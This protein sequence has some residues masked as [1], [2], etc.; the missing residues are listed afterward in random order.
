MQ[1]Q[2]FT[3][4]E[5]LVV[6]AIIAILASLLLPVLSKA[7]VRAQRTTC[8]NNLR[9][10]SL[11][12]HLY[13]GDNNDALPSI[14]ITN[15][16]PWSYQWRFFKELTKSYD[17]LSGSSSPQDTLF[18]CPA[19]IFYYS[20]VHSTPLIHGSMH[21]DPWADYSSYWFSRLNLVPNPMT[22]GFYHG[23][24]GL[25]IS[26]IR[27]PVQTLMVADQ[28]ACFAYSWHQPLPLTDPGPDKINDAKSMVGFVDGHVSY[29]NI[30]WD[31]TD[32][33]GSD[34]CFYNPPAGYEYQWGED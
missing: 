17:G 10:I 3:L 1:K 31:S 15:G 19:D 24:A 25:K 28:P 30:Y 5:L 21:D 18:A 9:Q 33:L 26:S 13:A 32:V 7:K 8:L 16:M 27:N 14:V 2:A 4:I 20:N 12:I 23:I 6:I 22:G 34:P 29:I 11:G